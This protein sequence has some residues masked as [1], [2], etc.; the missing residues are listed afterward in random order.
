MMLTV[1]IA[2]RM[3]KE[4]HYVVCKGAPHKRPDEPNS[5]LTLLLGC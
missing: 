4:T 1:F 2:Q 3:Y 5:G